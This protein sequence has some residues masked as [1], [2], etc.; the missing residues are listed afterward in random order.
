MD[1]SKAIKKDY[2]NLTI[3]DIMASILK[4]KPV[5]III[6]IIGILAG[7]TA[8]IIFTRNDPDLFYYAKATMIVTSKNA[9]GTYQASGN[10][11][12]PSASD[13][14]FA[15]NLVLTVTQ[16]AKSNYV[17]NLV[18][19]EIGDTYLTPDML[20]EFIACKVIEKNCV[21]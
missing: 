14:T 5:V 18:I 17:L 10:I 19:D 15:Q 7:I 3:S 6:V 21:Y 20:S 12:N 9:E 11:D 1:S 13:V 16:L 2:S 8:Q 4:Y